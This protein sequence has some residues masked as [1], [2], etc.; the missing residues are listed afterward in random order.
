MTSSKGRPTPHVIAQ[1]EVS[2]TLE[3]GVE[4]G[5]GVHREFTVGPLTVAAE[6]AAES[7]MPDFIDPNLLFRFAVSGLSDEERKEAGLAPQR[8]TKAEKRLAVRMADIRW[9]CQAV[10]RVTRLGG[11]PAEDIP[12]AVRMLLA[13]DLRDILS[14]A[15]EVD[16][17]VETFRAKNAQRV[18]ANDAAVANGDSSA[19]VAASPL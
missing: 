17:K 2:G 13:E 11:I 6:F 4:Y 7:E 15:R 9:K 10:Q 14:A 18:D 1:F 19:G 12:A 8:L 3:T 16:A 5:G